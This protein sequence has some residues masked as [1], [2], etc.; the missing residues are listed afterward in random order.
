MSLPL[1]ARE[2]IWKGVFP[3]HFTISSH[4]PLLPP[5]CSVLAF[6]NDK[7]TLPGSRRESAASLGGL[8]EDWRRLPPQDTL[9]SQ[10]LRFLLLLPWV[11]WLWCQRDYWGGRKPPHP[12]TEAQ[13]FCNR[14]IQQPQLGHRRLGN[15]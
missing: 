7:S 10:P 12:S 4:L 11:G 13:S 1:G 14:E 8:G 3:S 6:Q 9:S 2:Q 5:F 15:L